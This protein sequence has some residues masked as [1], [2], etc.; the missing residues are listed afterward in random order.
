MLDSKFF[1]FIAPEILDGKNNH[2]K[3]FKG[4]NG[5]QFEPIEDNND[6]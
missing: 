1:F 3:P 5:I 4:D 2:K 6:R